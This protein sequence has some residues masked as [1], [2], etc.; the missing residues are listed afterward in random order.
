MPRIF[1]VLFSLLL[2][3][4]TSAQDQRT[5]TVSGYVKDASSGETLIG[6]SVVDK[7][8]GR[9][10]NAN[11]FGYFVLSLSPGQHTLSASFIG[12]DNMDK[13]IDLQADMKLTIE[14]NP[15]SIQ[16]GAFEVI[17]ERSENNTEGTQMGTVDLDV[18]KMNTLPALLGEVDI[19]KVIQFLPG[20]Q[21]NGE[22]NSG[23]YVRGGGPDQHLT[24]A[25]RRLIE[26]PF[27]FFSGSMRMP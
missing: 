7:A 25:M 13:V 16:I 20:V 26:S 3:F 5:F 21:G 6:A 27:R 14:L 15:K 10:V 8:L 2:F 23:F 11:T 17:S 9:G 22:G 19:L 1:L 12:Y 4:S 18:Q 24:L